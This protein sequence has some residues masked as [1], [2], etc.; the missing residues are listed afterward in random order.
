[1]RLS[2]LIG[3]AVLTSF[4]GLSSCGDDDGDDTSE[5]GGT[6]GSGSG[7]KAGGS[8]GKS[9]KGGN[10]GSN[11]GSGG[12]GGSAG[13][14]ASGSAGQAGDDSAGGASG[15]PGTGGSSGDAGAS[16]SGGDSGAPGASGSTGESG[17]GGEAGSPGGSDTQSTA[18]SEFPETVM[19]G[20]SL[21]LNSYGAVLCEATDP[22]ACRLTTNTFSDGTNPCA[23]ADTVAFFSTLDT[24]HTLQL[25]SSWH[26]NSTT[27]GTIDDQFDYV[28]TEI[29]VSTEITVVIEAPGGTTYQM[30]FEFGAGREFTLTSFAEIV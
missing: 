27:A 1:M 10:A 17:S 12:N 18:C 15:S 6:S 29:P 26:I 22:N 8:S 2:G 20:E 25:N 16:G 3:L 14:G 11:A 13:K 9:G 5:A 24:D 23:N 28:L 4:V 7:G 21:Q 30:V 19:L